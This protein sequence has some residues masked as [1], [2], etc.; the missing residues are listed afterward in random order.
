MKY[1]FS[2]ESEEIV[3]ILDLPGRDI[4]YKEIES[5]S[6]ICGDAKAILFVNVASKSDLTENHFQQLEMIYQHLGKQNLQIIGFPCNQ[7]EK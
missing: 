6:E 2:E 4:H 5:L 7:F 3:D 1:G